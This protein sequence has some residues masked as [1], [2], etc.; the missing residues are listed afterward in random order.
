MHARR[1]SKLARKTRQEGG[2][3][4]RRT[5]MAEEETSK[6]KPSAAAEATR[7]ETPRARK[8]TARAESRHRRAASRMSEAKWPRG[9]EP[10]RS[11]DSART[12]LSEEGRSR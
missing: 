9:K 2:L 4:P 5:S 8:T 11:S 12:N 10:K 3:R 1:T 7:E 6:E